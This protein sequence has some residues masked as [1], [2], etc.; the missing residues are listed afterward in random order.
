MPQD[1]RMIAGTKV[2]TYKGVEIFVDIETVDD[3]NYRLASAIICGEEIT[4]C[5]LNQN[6]AVDGI[7]KVIDNKFQEVFSEGKIWK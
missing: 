2:E 5:K 3:C 1:Q 4:C 7:K 6:E